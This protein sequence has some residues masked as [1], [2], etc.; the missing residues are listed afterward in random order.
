MV[1][2]AVAAADE[3]IPDDSAAAGVTKSG[4]PLEGGTTFGTA[5]EGLTLLGTPAEEGAPLDA[6]TCVDEL[7]GG[8]TDRSCTVTDFWSAATCELSRLIC[9]ILGA[10]PGPVP[11]VRLNYFLLKMRG[12]KT[13]TADYSG[14]LALGRQLILAIARIFIPGAHWLPYLV[15][16]NLPGRRPVSPASFV[17]DF[18]G[19]YQGPG[20]PEG[21]PARPDSG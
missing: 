18:G 12:T 16:W 17:A 9:A 13:T 15:S 8:R 4:A 6:A 11:F 14:Q 7:A 2:F 3:R 19:A 5:A 1:S 10:G 20:L 21:T